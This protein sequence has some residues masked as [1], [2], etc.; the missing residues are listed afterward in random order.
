[1]L[2]TL[3]YRRVFSL[4]FLPFTLFASL[5]GQSNFCLLPVRLLSM[6]ASARPLTLTVYCFIASAP[7]HGWGYCGEVEPLT[8]LRFH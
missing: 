7:F 1:M 4:G 3:L 5:A 2:D 6:V 8:F